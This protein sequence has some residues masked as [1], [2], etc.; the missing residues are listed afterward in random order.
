M[1]ACN[2]VVTCPHCDMVVTLGVVNAE[3]VERAL[4][5]HLRYGCT[6]ALLPV[7]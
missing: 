1:I 3:Q 6:S 7:V 4:T 2:T 5:L